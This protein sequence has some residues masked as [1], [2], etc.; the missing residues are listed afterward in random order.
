MTYPAFLFGGLLATAFGVIFHL[1]KGGSLWRLIYYIIISWLGF[2]L[3]HTLGNRFNVSFF[4][5]GPLYAGPASLLSI[6]FLFFGYWLS[7]V[8]VHN[9]QK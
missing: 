1:L 3:G 7:L 2:W 6:A 8:E 4:Q 5:I 9:R